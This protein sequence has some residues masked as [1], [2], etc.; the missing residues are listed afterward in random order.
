MKEFEVRVLDDYDQ[1]FVS[2]LKDLGMSRN[3]ATTLTYLTNVPEASSQ[4]I[5]M[6]TG[7]R[8]PEVSVAM[9]RMRKNAWVN[10]HD[11]KTAG[12]GRPTKIY[13]LSAPVDQI[14]QHYENKILENTHATMTAI[15]KLK[16]ISKLV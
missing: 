15:D 14:I 6:S 9:R 13:S 10:V 2:A 1:K 4:E 8:Q 12:K 3:I 11:K 7:L 16:N 5:E